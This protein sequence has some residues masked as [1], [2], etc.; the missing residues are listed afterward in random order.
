VGY[1][2]R[3]DHACYC[4]AARIQSI[5]E[6][7]CT[8]WSEKLK[9]VE[10]NIKAF[11]ADGHAGSWF[12]PALIVNHGLDQKLWWVREFVPNL[13]MY[14]FI[15]V[16]RINVS[17]FYCPDILGNDPSILRDARVGRMM[18][19]I[20]KDNNFPFVR[21]IEDRDSKNLNCMC[22]NGKYMNQKGLIMKRF[23]NYLLGLRWLY[24]PRILCQWHLYARHFGGATMQA[25]QKV[26]VIIGDAADGVERW[27]VKS[28][29]KRTQKQQHEAYSP[30]ATT[31]KR[32]RVR[33]LRW[34]AW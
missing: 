21:R 6:F 30:I 1:P 26:W 19:N 33:R 16:K 24:Q 4:I 20:L 34:L 27:R 29:S 25:M 13:A 5:E 12:A 3:K 23:F 32:V 8:G 7:F 10:E 2:H 28:E 9:V 14:G 15:A 11:V 17:A 18:N 31:P 22:Q